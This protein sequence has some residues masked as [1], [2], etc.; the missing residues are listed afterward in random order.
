MLSVSIILENRFN[1]GAYFAGRIGAGEIGEREPADTEHFR[2]DL[3]CQCSQCWLVVEH[4]ENGKLAASV[5]YHILAWQPEEALG[6]EPP[7]GFVF[8]QLSA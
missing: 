2:L 8:R 6:V 3:A 7:E 1:F 4:S 5:F